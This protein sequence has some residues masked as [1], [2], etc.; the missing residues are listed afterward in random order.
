M[1]KIISIIVLATAVLMAALLV[2]PA[3]KPAVA[4]DYIIKVQTG[5]EIEAKYLAMGSHEVSYAEQAG[6]HDFKK[7]EIYYPSDITVGS[8]AYPVVIYSNGTGV[9]ASKYPAVLKHLAS[10]G[11]IVMAT[12]EENSWN[13]FSSEMCLRTVIML[14]ETESVDGWQSNPFYGH[15]DLDHIGVSGHSQGGVGVINAATE[16]K[17]GHMIKAIFSASPTNMPLAS[18]L[19]W[20]YDPSLITAPVFFVSSTGNADET[21]VVSGGQLKDIYDAV[22]ENVTKVM[23]RRT[24]AD[25][26][27]M[28]SFADGYMTAWFMWQLRGD[29]EAAGAFKG[30]RP[31]LMNNPLYQDQEINIKEYAY[32]A[33][34][35]PSKAEEGKEME[36]G[37]YDFIFF[38]NWKL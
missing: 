9:A 11:F 24:N 2:Y 21:V 19:Q 38:G 7:Y 12:E 4:N 3:K 28:L 17:H 36:E 1:L 37:K 26:G 31:E 6:M 27:D 25:H 15:V 30:D 14:N 32:T 33:S 13:G 8:S 16:N 35:L 18:A 29:Q 5:G 22:P 20:E 10:W 34:S 23:A